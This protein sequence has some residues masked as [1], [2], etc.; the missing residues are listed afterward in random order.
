MDSHEVKVEGRGAGFE[1]RVTAGSHRLVADEPARYGGGDAGPNPYDLLLAAIGSCTSM[2]VGLYAR[3]K[4]WPL[5][6]I[7]VRLRHARVHADDCADCEAPARYIERIEVTL[8]LGGPLRA[9]QRQRLREIAELCPVK[10]TLAG[11]LAIVTLL[12]PIA[13]G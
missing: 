12:A 9:E 2:T 13:G 8:E 1:Q 6:A 11:G 5:E 7:T 10:K 4:Q 3:R